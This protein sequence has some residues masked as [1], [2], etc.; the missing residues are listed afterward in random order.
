MGNASR[1]ISD[2]RN[3]AS[4]E[5]DANELT[6]IDT[7]MNI[8]E[9]TNML[10][11]IKEEQQKDTKLK[12]IID[13]ILMRTTP[14]VGTNRSPYVVINGLLYKIRKAHKHQDHR[15]ISNKHL[16]VI[17]TSRRNKLIAWAHDHPM[18]G[19]AGRLKTIHRLL[20]RVFWP[21][22][23]KDVYKYTQQCTLCQQFK[24]D[25]KP[26]AMPMQLHTVSEPWHTIGVDLMGPFPT[27]QTQKEYLFV[28]VDYFTRWVEMFPLR[29]T[30][31]T[32]MANTL[33]N[34]VF[35]RYGMPTYIL[36]DNGP[37]FV[38][39]LFTEICQSLGI[40][41][42]LTANYHPQTNMTERVNRT[43]KQQIRIYA[44]HNPKFWDREIQKLAF[45]L[46]TSIN[47][48]IGET[49]AFLNFGRNLKRN[50]TGCK[51]LLH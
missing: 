18:A 41:Q 27:T 19:H 40:Q 2:Q 49:P 4:I 9:S 16:L 50:L 30:T 38:A 1:R 32:T 31:A 33:I 6:A 21:Q 29:N 10:D 14:T 15:I 11:D 34:E 25:N 36:S 45:A 47:V 13:D 39:E 35:C 44:Q 5:E 23:R 17:P 24:Y 8:W 51:T 37:Q 7:A 20:P 48:T 3:Q 28:V 43:I 42:K 22:M 46:R 12:P 26:L